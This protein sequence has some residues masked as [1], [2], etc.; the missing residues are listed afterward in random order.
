MLL[1]Q[2]CRSDLETLREPFLSE[3]TEPA[4]R[5]NSANLYIQDHMPS[6]RTSYSLLIRTEFQA[7]RKQVRTH[8]CRTIDPKAFSMNSV[9]SV[10]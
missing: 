10:D 2:S 3:V 9:N 8:N 6:T 1:P 7:P 5:C 4:S